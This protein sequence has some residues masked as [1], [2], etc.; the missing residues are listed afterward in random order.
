MS[1]AFSL[2]PLNSSKK[3][4]Q[5]ASLLC[6]WRNSNKLTIN[7]EKCHVIIFT[8]IINSNVKDFFVTLNNS[9]ITLK[10]HVKY[11]GVF[12]D[13]KLNFHFHLNAV[14]NKFSRALG[15]LCKLK[16]VLPQNA[17]LKLYYSL[18][19]PH[20]PYG[21]VAWGSTFPTYLL[22]LASTQNKV[23]KLI[24]GGHALD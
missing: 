22:K 21:I 5:K 14:A 8:P 3:L 16:H 15:I 6:N 1:S 7:T 12:I 9:P 2:K 24:E 10:N 11:L 13:S 19:H 20:L 23:V 4:N 17:L 18:V